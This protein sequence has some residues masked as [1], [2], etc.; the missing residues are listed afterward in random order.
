MQKSSQVLLTV[1]AILL[2]YGR[3]RTHELW[4]ELV[5]VLLRIFAAG[6]AR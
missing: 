3:A 6:I 2:P 4:I 5:V 1:V